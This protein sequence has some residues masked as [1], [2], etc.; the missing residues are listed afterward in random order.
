LGEKRQ[1]KLIRDWKL[2]ESRLDMDFR[3][4]DIE[5]GNIFEFRNR[6]R[7]G[8]GLINRKRIKKI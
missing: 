2:E 7:T 8:E 4:E 6:G 3:D 5:E 1:D